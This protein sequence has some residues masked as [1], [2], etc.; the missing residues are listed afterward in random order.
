MSEMPQHHRGFALEVLLGVVL[1]G[2]VAVAVTGNVPAQ[3]RAGEADGIAVTGE[4]TVTAVPDR[5]EVTLG[6]ES[7]APSAVEAQR[8]NARAMERVLAALTKAGVDRRDVQTSEYSLTPVRR[9]DEKAHKN[10]LL[11]YRAVNL[12]TVT[13]V[14][15]GAVG[16]LADAAVAAGATNVQNIVFDVTDK[17]KLQQEALAEA[18]AEA[19][20]KADR[21]ARAA[22]VRVGKVR[23]MADATSVVRPAYDQAELAGLRTLGPQDSAVP[24]ERGRLRLTSRVHVTFGLR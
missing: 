15:T 10:V 14:K 4:A 2:L 3:R 18:V 6:L 22:G 1:V 19:R 12:V 11:G 16:R 21:L 9:W 24:L 7:E 13:T 23:S 5:A 8:A 20:A 17:S